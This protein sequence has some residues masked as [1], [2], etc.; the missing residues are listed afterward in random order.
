MRFRAETSSISIH[1]SKSQISV[2]SFIIGVID[3]ESIGTQRRSCSVSSVDVDSHVSRVN[4]S[5]PWRFRNVNFASWKLNHRL[6]FYYLQVEEKVTFMLFRV[7]VKKPANGGV[8]LYSWLNRSKY[9]NF[10]N[11]V[12]LCNK[13][14]KSIILR[15]YY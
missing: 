11:L 4:L 6:R 2:L 10:R 14:T 3:F 5:T 1:K 12:I 9:F 13:F 15:D 8:N 7:I